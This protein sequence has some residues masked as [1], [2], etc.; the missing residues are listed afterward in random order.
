MQG[1]IGGVSE[2]LLKKERIC[3]S[4]LAGNVGFIIFKEEGKGVPMYRGKRRHK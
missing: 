2:T 1:E 4:A 3:R